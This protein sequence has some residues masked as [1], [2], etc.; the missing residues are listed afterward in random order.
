MSHTDLIA[1][2]FTQALM[3]MRNAARRDD[4]DARERFSAVCAALQDAYPREV[5][6][7]AERREEMI[8]NAKLS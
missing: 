4:K 1:G 5:R 3:D 8:R 7:A 6:A 2:V